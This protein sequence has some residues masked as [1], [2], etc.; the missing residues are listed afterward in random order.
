MSKATNDNAMNKLN[1][2]KP[3]TNALFNLLFII[4][5]L[6]CVIPILYVFMIS[7]SSEAS[8]TKYVISSFPMN[9]P[10]LRIGSCGR[11][12]GPF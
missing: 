4:L 6:T 11:N 1:R 5:G 10:A 12:G 2:I 7:I 8:I 9:F 3:G